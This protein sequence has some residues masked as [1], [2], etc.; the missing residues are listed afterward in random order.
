MSRSETKTRFEITS[1]DL[2]VSVQR[3]IEDIRGQAT[4]TTSPTTTTS[5]RDRPSPIRVCKDHNL[6]AKQQVAA[7][8]GMVAVL[9]R[10]TMRL[11]REKLTDREEEMLRGAEGFFAEMLGHDNQLRMFLTGEA[12]TGKSVV[13]GAILD[14]TN[15]W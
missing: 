9:Q 7:L 3:A 4:Q 1:E 12:G 15:R 10:L 13:I 11:D 8:F 14:F 5:L 6:N 2:L